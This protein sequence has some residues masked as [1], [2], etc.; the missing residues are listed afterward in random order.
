MLSAGLGGMLLFFFGG[1]RLKT[2]FKLMKLI[3]CFFLGGLV[4]L[5]CWIVDT[6]SYNSN[7]LGN[8][9]PTVKQI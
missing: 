7:Q 2:N 3:F 9:L 4:G 8:M 1:E 5:C 6:L